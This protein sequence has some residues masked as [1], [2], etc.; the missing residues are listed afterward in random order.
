VAVYII[1]FLVI[2]LAICLGATSGMGGGV[3]IK[4]LL[5][6]IGY[7]DLT[8]ITFYSSVAV[9][10]MSISSTYKQ[11]KN[12]IQV[13]WAS[14]LNIS[15]GAIVGGLIGNQ[16]FNHLIVY[17]GNDQTVQLTQV[18]LTVLCMLFVLIY[19]LFIKKSFALKSRIIYFIAGVFLGTI[20]VLLGIGGGPIN[21]ALLLLLFDLSMKEATVYSIITIFFSQIA[22][23]GQIGF[24]T[25]FGIFDLS[26]LLV[27]IP[28]ALLG[29]YLG[30]F[31]SGKVSNKVV[32]KIFI[33]ADILVII[34]NLYNGATILL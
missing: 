18:A 3:I 28:A 24:S 33:F 2:I 19:T 12:G 20:S 9:F 21:V 25:G 30:G 13:R 11:L 17:F 6:L 29:G 10:T 31:I 14:A 7:H 5:D 4:P 27:V 8:S 23:L 32:S 1:Y 22:K 34:I 26:F 15:M 16:L